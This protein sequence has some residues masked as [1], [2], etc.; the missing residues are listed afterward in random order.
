MPTLNWA[1]KDKVIN[2]HLDVP[3]RVLERMYTFGPGAGI[4]GSAGILP[5]DSNMVIHGD[6]LAALKALL[7]R[8]EGRVDCIYI[9]PPYNTGNEGWVYN[10]NVNDPQIRKWLGEVV[11]REG[12]DFSR[13]DK[14]LCMMYPRLRLLHRLLANDGVIFIS[15]DD[16]EQANLRSVCDEI[17]GANNFVETFIWRKADSPSSNTIPV[18]SD[19]EYILAYAK[20]KDN[21]RLVPMEAPDI[22]NAYGITDEAGRRCRDRLLKKNG[23]NSLRKDRPT[24]FFP[25]VAPDGKEVF[26]IHDNGEEAR[27]SMGKAGVAE[28]IAAGRIIWKKRKKQGEEVWEPYTRE[29]APNN[30]TRPYPTIWNDVHTMRQAK[31]ELREIFNTADL[32]DT[33]KP[34]NL[35]ERILSLIGKKDALVLD[36]FAGSGT[37]AHAVLKL[38]AE[39][40][41]NRRFILVEMMDY[42]E[43]ITA[44]RVKRVIGSLGKH[45]DNAPSLQNS[46][47]PRSESNLGFGYYE[48]GPAL[49]DGDALNEN[50]PV[51]KIREY[52]WWMETRGMGNVEICN[53]GNMGL[54]NYGNDGDPIIPQSHNSTIPQSHN[55]Y[56][57]GAA[58]GTAYYFCYEPGRAVALNR[59]LLRKI[60]TK[61]EAYVIYADR[62][63]L[64]EAT[65]RRLRITFKKIPRDIARL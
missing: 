40:G 65:L 43:S 49:M 4:P 30:P 59:A 48:L 15:I 29:Y 52:V 25:L 33:P 53:C 39:D 51:G 17:F 14:W 31:A 61:A 45:S 58:D 16:N 28:L 5:A 46:Q 54:W 7:P 60:G 26:P 63:L 19:H 50:L 55:D 6:N 27:W 24:M 35:L 13:H 62:C 9:D 1:G 42:A 23:R 11:G 2:H 36:S 21:L 3:M 22:V 57:L 37:T 8:Y 41:G 18:I 38:N 56:L 64:D 34:T 32:F 20:Q 47:S 10:D 12:E 44:E